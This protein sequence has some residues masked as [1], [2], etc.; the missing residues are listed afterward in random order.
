M[1][2]G[3]DNTQCCKKAIEPTVPSECMHLCQGN[4]KADGGLKANMPDSCG[5]P[6]LKQAIKC[7]FRHSSNNTAIIP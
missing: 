7:H 6:V 4:D 2:Q 5:G 3:R 1:A